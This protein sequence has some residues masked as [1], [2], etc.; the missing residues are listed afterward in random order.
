MRY[1]S[2]YGPDVSDGNETLL[3]RALTAASAAGELLGQR[4]ERLQVAEKS[5]ATDAVTEMDRASEALLVE[6]LLEDGPDDAVLGE[7]GGERHGASGVRWVLD[8]LDGTVNYLYG[9]PEWAVSVA[10]EVDGEVMAAVVHA[11]VLATTWWATSGG[12]AWVRSHADNP[13]RIT[14]G[15]EDR[16]G[17]ALVGTGFGYTVPRRRWQGKVLAEVITEV[18]DIRRAG[19]AAIDLCRVAQ[20]TLDGM[21]ERGLQPWDHAAGGLIV[22]E[23][24]GVIGDLVGGPAGESMTIAANP[25]LFEQLRDVVA[26]AVES[27]GSEQA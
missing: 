21:F 2:G 3:Q 16:L 15:R 9:I 19:A 25:P 8:P 26:G 5:S 4:P 23:A 24:Q 7:E 12:G 10:A 17:H 13:R 14:V 11:P 20:G 1:G 18:R 6:L 27:A 22:A